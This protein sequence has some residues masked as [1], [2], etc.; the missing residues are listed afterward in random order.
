MMT[1][2]QNWRIVNPLFLM[3]MA[4]IGLASSTLLKNSIRKTELF[5]SLLLPE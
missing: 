1:G 5:L 2:L 3:A 4:I